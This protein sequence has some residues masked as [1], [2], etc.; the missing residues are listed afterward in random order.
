M[1][2]DKNTCARVKSLP[3]MY[4]K[5]RP[6]QYRL[7]KRGSLSSDYLRR[8]PS[9]VGRKA[10]HFQESELKR[11]APKKNKQQQQGIPFH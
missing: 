4:R 2:P 6:T 1:F 10:D 5:L 9:F 3:C 8:I 11:T 7:D